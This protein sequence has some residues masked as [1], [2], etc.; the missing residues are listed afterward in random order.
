MIL[1]AVHIF[2]RAFLSLYCTRS[3]TLHFDRLRLCQLDPPPH[4]ARLGQ[5]FVGRN[6]QLRFDF[7][8]L[9]Q[10]SKFQAECSIPEEAEAIGQKIYR[11]EC[12]C[13]TE[14]LTWWNEGEEFA[15]L[16]IGHFI[17]YPKDKKGPFE[18]TFPA[19]VVFLEEKK[20]ELPS[21]IKEECPWN[22][23]REFNEKM[24]ERKKELQK[25]LSNTIPLQAAFI[26][27][28]FDMRI[29]KLFPDMSKIES[30]ART[31]QG[32]F[33][34]I[35]YLHF[36]G[37]GSSEQERYQGSGWGLKQVIDEM[38]EDAADPLMAFTQAAKAVLKRRVQNAPPQRREER[39]LPGW[40]GRVEGYLR[41]VH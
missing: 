2:F 16:G 21:W 4:P 7:V 11:N 24:Q 40:L 39:W 1:L 6:A 31:R 29:R 22:S 34:L 10:N 5:G 20:T 37:D 12:S 27:Q 41:D 14:K 35:D 9:S 36:K 15:S 26:V 38:P 19:L 30:V 33:A 3:E 13:Q 25:L 32:R 17:W 28:R 8:S 18:E 23:K